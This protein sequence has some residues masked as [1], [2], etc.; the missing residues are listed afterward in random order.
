MTELKDSPTN[1]NAGYLPFGELNLKVINEL[2]HKLNPIGLHIEVKGESPTILL[3]L[4]ASVLVGLRD[5]EAI[6]QVATELMG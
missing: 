1:T 2:A 5:P 3:L 4:E 6:A